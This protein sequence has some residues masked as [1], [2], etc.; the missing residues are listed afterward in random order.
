MGL[1][2][3]LLAV[4]A[5]DDSLL[6]VAGCSSETQNQCSGTVLGKATDAGSR[7]LREAEA[8]LL[9]KS[10]GSSQYDSFVAKAFMADD[11]TFKFENVMPGNYQLKLAKG[12]LTASASFDLAGGAIKDLGTMKLMD[13]G[14]NAWSAGDGLRS[15][16]RQ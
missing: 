10:V 4:W 2:L 8:T 12:S 7:D 15:V 5:C 13:S 6:K 1:F 14:I 16:D 3:L 11:G 9:Q